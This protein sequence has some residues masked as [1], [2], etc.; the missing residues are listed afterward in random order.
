ML[1]IQRRRLCGLQRS[2]TQRTR[3][4][5]DEAAFVEWRAPLIGDPGAFLTI[6]D[7]QEEEGTNTIPSATCS[8]A[9]F[10][11]DDSVQFAIVFK[12]GRN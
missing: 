1:S 6:T 11:N 3:P 4:S 2:F 5:L 8:T 7:R 12:P 10:E 9:A